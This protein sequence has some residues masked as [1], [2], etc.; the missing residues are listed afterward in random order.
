MTVAELDARV[1]ALRQTEE[2]LKEPWAGAVTGAADDLI[3][4]RHLLLLRD[5][6]GGEA[7]LDAL[8]EE[9][10]CKRA[11]EAAGFRRETSYTGKVRIW[12]RHSQVT[13]EFDTWAEARAWAEEH[14]DRW[15]EPVHEMSVERVYELLSLLFPDH[16]A[17]DESPWL[18]L[19]MASHKNGYGYDGKTDRVRLP[20]VP[21]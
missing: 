1:R 9:A 6:A 12:K 20:E 10:E 2:A 21:Q 13:D 4:I 15:S 16:G 17:R 8:V 18:Y 19:R 3:A 7:E 14:A 11:I 5:R